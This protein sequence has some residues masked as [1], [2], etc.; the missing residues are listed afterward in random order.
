MDA[1]LHFSCEVV[2]PGQYVVAW[3][4]VPSGWIVRGSAS[5]AI[6]GKIN[7]EWVKLYTVGIS[8]P[9]SIDALGV[10]PGSDYRIHLN[11]VGNAFRFRVPELKPAMYRVTRTL[12]RRD[13]HGLSVALINAA[14]FIAVSSASAAP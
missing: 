4:D 13:E 1:D 11:A 10:W 12:R 9:T 6:S 3:A 14:G 5:A 8:K 2:E 7:G